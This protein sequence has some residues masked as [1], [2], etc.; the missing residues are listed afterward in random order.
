MKIYN[1]NTGAI[2][3]DNQPGANDATLPIQAVGSNSTV[4]ISGTNSNL[5]SSNTNQNVEIDTKSSEDVNELEVISYPNP[6]ITAFSVIVRAD[7]NEKVVI[8][9]FDIN[10]RLIETRNV[11]P[12]SITKLGD[13]YVPGA[14]VVRIMQGKKY[15]QIKLVKLPD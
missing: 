4:V 11:N 15:K 2:I 6:T 5:T 13:N 3:Y 14:Y 7:A 8:Q 9:V 12:Y 1:K 10:G